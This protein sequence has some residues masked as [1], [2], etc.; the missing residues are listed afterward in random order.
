MPSDITTNIHTV[1]IINRAG[2]LVYH[3]DSRRFNE[4][5][6]LHSIGHR[7]NDYMAMGSSLA[8]V[9]AI[10]AQLADDTSH[11]DWNGIERID[12]SN[13]RIHCW[14]SLSGLKI[15]LIGSADSRRSDVMPII[16]AIHR[17]YCDF[18]LKDPCHITDMPIKSVLFDRAI[19][20]IIQ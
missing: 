8:S 10:A 11:A 1:L 2:G 19:S 12:Y 18:V 4:H 15:L 20:K 17:C 7:S 13:Q 16:Q 14:Q 3:K 6:S 9:Y 5:G